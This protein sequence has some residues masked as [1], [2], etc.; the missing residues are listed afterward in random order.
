MAFAGEDAALRHRPLAPG[1]GQRRH[2]HR[3]VTV[4]Q[5]TAPDREQTHPRRL[6]QQHMVGRPEFEVA[7]SLHHVE[8]LG[9]TADQL[10]LGRQTAVETQR[11]IAHALWPVEQ[12]QPGTADDGQ[13]AVH[14]REGRERPVAF[15]AGDADAQHPVVG[16]RPGQQLAGHATLVLP[17]LRLHVF[18]AD[19]APTHGLHLAMH[20]ARDA[21]NWAFSAA[22][23]ALVH[24]EK[25]PCNW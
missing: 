1:Q 10:G 11:L 18:R 25:L 20:S 17:G 9:L 21:G 3:P 6:R 13:P 15:H 2:R 19:P 12:A 5:Q 22:T 8:D 14:P 4:L 23:R 7:A 24:A 16:M